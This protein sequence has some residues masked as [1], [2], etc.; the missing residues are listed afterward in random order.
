MLT[1]LRE[2]SGSFVVKILLVFLVISFGAWGI[3]DYVTGGSSGGAVA[4]V[5]EQEISPQDFAM[6]YRREFV[7]LRQFF[8]ESL[9]PDTARSFGIPESVVRRMVRE[10]LLNQAAQQAGLLPSDGDVLA[11]LQGMDQ[12]KGLT[13]EFDRQVFAE[14]LVR[15]GYSEAG[16]VELVRRELARE[17]LLSGLMKRPVVADALAHRLF[18]FEAETRDLAV[19]V[20]PAQS[21]PEAEIP[22]ES[23]VSSYYE[24]NKDRFQAPAYRKITYIKIGPDAVVDEIAVSEEDIAAAYDARADAFSTPARRNVMQMVFDQQEQA[25]AAKSLLDAGESFEDV[26]A[27]LAGL[28]PADVALGWVGEGDLLD[29]I[30]APV[31]SADAGEVLGPLESILGWHVLLINDAESAEVTPLADVRDGLIDDLKRERALDRVFDLANR[32]DEL[33]GAGRRLEDVAADLNIEVHHLDQIDASGLDSNGASVSGPDDPAFAANV[34]AEEIGVPSTLIEVADGYYAF[35]VDGET[36]SRQ[37]SLNEVRADI[38]ADLMAQGRVENARRV[39]EELAAAGLTRESF[40]DAA[41]AIGAE[42]V[43]WEGV[44]RNGEGLADARLYADLIRSA[45]DAGVRETV[46][47]PVGDSFAAAIVLDVRSPDPAA[48]PDALAEV[49]R[50]VAQE[51]RTD[52]TDLTI[53]GLAQRIGTTI[54]AQALENAVY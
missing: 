39:A 25:Q 42:V 41:S 45:F 30:A 47:S 4:V 29:E 17:A 10:E 53:R 21:V 52:L 50:N 24:E 14:A 40:E 31:F 16:F 6:E 51:L 7:R 48:E 27:K 23:E 26:A 19:A 3:G 20:V 36:P 12:F 9:T 13:G 2:K 28:S 33:L 22:D 34:F 18:R 46:I 38:I 1:S 43:L 32:A 11:T 5:G 37:L 49:E 44:L 54:D 8:G 35:R 15:A